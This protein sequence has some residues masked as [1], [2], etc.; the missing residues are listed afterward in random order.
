MTLVIRIPKRWIVEAVYLSTIAISEK[1]CCGFG[2]KILGCPVVSARIVTM[3]GAI[4]VIVTIVA[5]LVAKD[6]AVRPV[7]DMAV[8]GSDNQFRG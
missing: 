8:V 5:T 2:M 4:A 6:A 7:A 3:T 1:P